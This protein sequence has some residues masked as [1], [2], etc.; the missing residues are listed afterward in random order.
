MSALLVSGVF[1]WLRPNV[2]AH[3]GSDGLF[4]FGSLLGLFLV[5]VLAMVA[6]SA[7]A[8]RRGWRFARVEGVV[9]LFV[10]AATALLAAFPIPPEYVVVELA[11]R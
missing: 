9:V 6:I 4:V 8:W 11:G 2:A 7:F 3:S 10:L 1:V 5:G